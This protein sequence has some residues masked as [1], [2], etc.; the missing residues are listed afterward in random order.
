MKSWT[1]EDRR[2]AP[3]R[4]ALTDRA[5]RWVTVQVGKHGRT[6]NEVA[7][8]L[9]C[10]WH[11]VNDA[12]IAYGTALVDD[13]DRIGDVTALGLDET[14]FCRQGRW[15]R[16]A[17][18]TRI[19]DVG[20]GRLLDVV[21]G[22]DTTGPSGWLTARGEERCQRIEWATLDLSGPYRRM[23]DTMLPDATQV[24]DPFH[25]VRAP[26]WG[27]RS[28]PPSGPERND[29]TSGPQRRP[30]VSDPASPHQGR[31]SSHRTRPHQADGTPRRRRS[32]G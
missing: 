3:A 1:G 23:F 28:V 21:E 6:V 4:L 18:S 31:R 10:D 13:K 2:I 12:V 19:V 26:K 11:T 32:E 5:G 15:R 24:A 20:A 9:G 25:V 17:W 29:G 22:R 14:L 7:D 30:A 27:A 16:Q 8:K